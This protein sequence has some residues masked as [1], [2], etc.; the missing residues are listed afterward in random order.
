MHGP[1]ILKLPPVN[2]ADAVASTAAEMKPY[3]DVIGG[4][5][6]KFEMIPIPGGQVYD[7]KPR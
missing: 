6:V 3:T 2:A 4:A 7:G 1:L 5:D